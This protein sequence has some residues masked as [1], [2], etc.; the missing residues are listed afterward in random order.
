MYSEVAKLE[1]KNKNKRK[2]VKIITFPCH[3]SAIVTG[4]QETV[5]AVWY[6]PRTDHERTTCGA[7][8]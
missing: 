5:W 6:L 4:R 1:K 7:Q 8:L 3:R 2:L